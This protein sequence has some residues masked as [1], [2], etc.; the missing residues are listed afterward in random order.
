MK[1][2]IVLPAYNESENLKKGALEEIRNYLEKNIKSYE[3]IIVDDGS[4]DDSVKLIENF[5]KG[6]TN[7]RLIKNNHGGKAIAVMTGLLN[8][9][10]EVGLFADMDQATPISEV[11]KLLPFFK[12][13]FDIVIGS[14]EGRKGAPL[15]RKLMAFGFSMIRT[16]ILGLP[17]ED[18]Q[19]GFKAFNRRSI[20]SIFPSLKERW[21]KHLQKKGAA[22]NAAFD[23]ETL[24]IAKKLGYKIKEVKVE[25]HHVGTERVQ[26]LRDSF[27]AIIDILKIRVNDL[28]GGYPSN[29]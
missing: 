13:G 6:K 29:V 18:T 14:R 25:W 8:C 15:I 10:G 22:V 28:M 1:L 4:S 17:F 9:K 11:E 7:F 23:V 2:S 12:E 27:D 3:V 19:C 26:V 24:F 5:I 21:H 16:I 20:D